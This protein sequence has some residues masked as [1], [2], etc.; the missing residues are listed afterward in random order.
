MTLDRDRIVEICDNYC[1]AMS[2]G[3]PDATTA[4]FAPDA[5]HEEPVGTPVRHGHE[6]IRGFFAQHKDIGFKLTRL[7]PATVVGNRAAFQVRVEVP[8]PEGSR[9]LAATDLI[10]VSDDGLIAGIVVYP[11]AQA[12]PDE[13]R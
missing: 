12:D 5:S 9:F 13:A 3:D 2:V 4:L 11:D 1:A 7:G 8:T 10:T 6:E